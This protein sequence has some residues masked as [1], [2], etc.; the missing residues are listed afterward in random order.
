M[1][2]KPTTALRF[3]LPL[4][5]RAFDLLF[6][7]ICLIVL[8][9]VMAAVALAIR[10]ESKGPIFY[11]SCRVGPG[12][13][14]FNFY[15]F[16]SMYV[17]ADKHIAELGKLNQYSTPITNRSTTVANDFT[18]LVSDDEQISETEYL[19]KHHRAQEE[20]FV[21]LQSDPRVTRVGRFIRKYSLDELPQL[22]N[23]LRGD[24]S[25]VGNRPLPLYE[26]EKL[27]TDEYVERFMAPA[28]LTGLWQVER[29]GKYNTMSAQ[30]RK[31]LDIDYAR[32]Y[33][34]WLDLRIL[35]RTITAFIQKEDV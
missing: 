1:K 28:G 11:A 4:W 18:M 8:S 3:S 30:E 9:P 19:R 2:A 13:K 15:K 17:D 16:R 21:K 32:H 20:A 25:V 6:S 23:I 26:A 10:L 22:Y 5:K 14:I 35:V 34:L 24:M 12:Y 33:N 31:M 7:S 29:R 27:T